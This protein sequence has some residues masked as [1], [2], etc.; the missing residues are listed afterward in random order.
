LKKATAL[1]SPKHLN[2]HQRRFSIQAYLGIH[3]GALNSKDLCVA[4]GTDLGADV[5]TDVGVAV[6]ADDGAYVVPLDIAWALMSVL[7]S[8]LPFGAGAGADVETHVGDGFGTDVGDDG[9]TPAFRRSRWV[10]VG[11][12]GGVDGVGV[13]GTMS[14]LQSVQSSESVGGRRRLVGVDGWTLALVV[15][16]VALTS[17]V[18]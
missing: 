5:G 17:L 14:D 10:D 18:Q 1:S 3:I 13:V 2:A 11:V 9:W 7:E 8:A 15:E 6:G 16:L 4:V 12:G